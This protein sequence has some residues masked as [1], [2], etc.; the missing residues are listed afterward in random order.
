MDVVPSIQ[1]QAVLSRQNFTNFILCL[2]L[3][4]HN[5]SFCYHQV[6]G[7]EVREG[8]GHVLQT[9]EEISQDVFKIRDTLKHTQHEKRKLERKVLSLQHCLEVR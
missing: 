9:F 3:T 1:K 5:S 6:P 2:Y 4:V 7:H 8:L